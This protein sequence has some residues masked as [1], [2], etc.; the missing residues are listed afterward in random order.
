MDNM[1]EEWNRNSDLEE[2]MTIERNEWMRKK[3]MW[4]IIVI[5]NLSGISNQRYVRINYNLCYWRSFMLFCFDSCSQPYMLWL[6]LL[7]CYLALL[8]YF[9]GGLSGLTF[10]F[11]FNILHFGM[12]LTHIN[13]F[14]MLFSCLGNSPWFTLLFLSIFLLP[15][16]PRGKVVIERN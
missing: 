11:E 2:T 8:I 10:H 7:H 3:Y 14:C 6:K 9:L 1:S 12:F 13:I 5:D 4:M 16:I 15:F